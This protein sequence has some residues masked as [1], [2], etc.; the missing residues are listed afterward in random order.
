MKLVAIVAGGVVVGGSVLGGFAFAA[1]GSTQPPAAPSADERPA[2]TA[3][4]AYALS[5]PVLETWI[6]DDFANAWIVVGN[7]LESASLALDAAAGDDEA[8]AVW[9]ARFE[10]VI[11]VADAV[12]DAD[13]DA[14]KAAVAPLLVEEPGPYADAAV[15][16][17][18]SGDP[19]ADADAALRT[20]DTA[21]TADDRD[22]ARQAVAD[23]AAALAEVVVWSQVSLPA[24]DAPQVLARV[25]PAFHA[26]DGIQDAV[27]GGSASDA[28]AAAGDLHD[29]FDAFRSWSQELAA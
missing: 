3:E 22:A 2:A 29:A 27:L 6:R 15:D 4:Q 17:T 11:A 13:Q 23:A 1:A 5:L 24:A 9:V 19:S 28:A 10:G 12:A 20:L 14:A 18:L 8:Y 21:I 25:L 16:T 26:I 7:T